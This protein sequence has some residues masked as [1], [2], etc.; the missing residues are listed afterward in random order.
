M[1]IDPIGARYWEGIKTVEH[2]L[3]KNLALFRPFPIK[4]QKDASYVGLQILERWR[5][6]SNV[7]E[8]IGKLEETLELRTGLCWNIWN[9]R[10]QRC[11]E[12]KRLIHLHTDMMVDKP[13]E[14]WNDNLKVLTGEAPIDGG[15]VC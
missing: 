6:L 10:N 1:P 8:T 13:V 12:I 7:V 11:F 9:P 2:M 14:G 5:A 4:F 15:Q 3:A